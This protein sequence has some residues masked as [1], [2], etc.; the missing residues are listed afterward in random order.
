MQ[1]SEFQSVYRAEPFKPFVINMAD[2]RSVSVGH[3]EFIAVSP[4]GRTAVVF[5]ENGSFEIV[6]VMLVTSISVGNGKTKRS[7]K[8]RR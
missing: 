4:N 1:A 8:K 3:P 6:D 2:G 5:E 7:S